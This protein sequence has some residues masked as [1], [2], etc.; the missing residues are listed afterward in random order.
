MNQNQKSNITEK[1]V[2]SGA[3][4]ERISGFLEKNTDK[5]TSNST[6]WAWT[7][8]GPNWAYPLLTSLSGNKSD[9][10]IERIYKSSS[11]KVGPCSIENTL[12]F[13]HKNLYTT[14]Y[15]DKILLYLRL[16]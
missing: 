16:V 8:S 9:R 5:Y 12:T 14:S 6:P 7:E 13:T 2:E 11:E 15:E 10:L 3:L 4:L 1:I